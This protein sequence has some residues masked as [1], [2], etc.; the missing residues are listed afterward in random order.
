MIKSKLMKQHIFFLYHKYHHLI[1]YGIIGSFSSSLD[2]IIYTLLVE[3]FGFM[4]VLANSI[5]ILAGI[6]TSFFMNRNFNFKVKD[7]TTRRF[8]IFLLVGLSG[9]LISNIILYICVDI[10]AIDKIISKLLSIIF[11]VFFQFLVNKYVTFK[12]SDNE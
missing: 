6:T 3:A 9:L 4:Y 7:H 5:S 8:T 2:F 12:Q 11:V 10:M 1:L